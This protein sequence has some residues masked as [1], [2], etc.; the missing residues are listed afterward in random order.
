[1]MEMKL[2]E[3]HN[4]PEADQKKVNAIMALAQPMGVAH[5][6][7]VTFHTKDA[8]KVEWRNKRNGQLIHSDFTFARN[9]ITD[10]QRMLKNNVRHY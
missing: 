1:M 4:L 6:I 9:F 3:T 8:I 2:T 10:F 5:E 7:T